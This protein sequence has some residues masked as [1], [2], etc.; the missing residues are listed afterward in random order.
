MMGA[1]DERTGSHVLADRVRQDSFSPRPRHWRK[2]LIQRWQQ[3]QEEEEECHHCQC[4]THLDPC[5]LTPG[6]NGP[7]TGR[8]ILPTVKSD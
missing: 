4:R 6:G 7:S 8:A 3:Q 2:G 5:E 1:A